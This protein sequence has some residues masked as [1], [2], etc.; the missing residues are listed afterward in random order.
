MTH[1]IG[2]PSQ[3]VDDIARERVRQ[4]QHAL[5][6]WN[7]DF[8]ATVKPYVQDLARVGESSP[9]DFYSD[10]SRLGSR[11]VGLVNAG[12]AAAQSPDQIEGKAARL[13]YA[14]IDRHQVPVPTLDEPRFW[15]YLSIAYFWPFTV[16]R[17]PDSF[18]TLARSLGSDEGEL[19]SHPSF[20]DDSD[21]DEPGTYMDYLDGTKAWGCVPLRMYLR[22][23][24]LGG[25]D[26]QGRASAIKK[27]TDFWQSHVLRI[28]LGDFPDI[29]RAMV[30][31]QKTD[32]T[33]LTYKPLRRVAKRLSYAAFSLDCSVLSKLELRNLVW[34]IWNTESQWDGLTPW[35]ADPD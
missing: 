33:Y 12:M 10:L 20:D 30:D 18:R 25:S 27:G 9:A 28:R 22:I 4:G 3:A 16:W 14:V 1:L 29:V 26:R 2:L 5:P 6:N 35:E 7:L 24:A 19:E 21:S 15:A 11:L 23:K 8:T 13:L 34:D 17:Q 32:E 31:L